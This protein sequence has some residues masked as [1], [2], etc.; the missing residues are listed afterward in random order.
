MRFNVAQLLKEGVGARRWYA[1][2]ETIDTLPETGTTRVKGEV[3]VTRIDK[4][5]W[6]NGA[7]ETNASCACSRCL[8]QAEY[9]V[10]FQ[11]DEEYLPTVDIDTG[12]TL[13]VEE[14]QEVREGTFTLDQNH[15]LDLTEAIRQYVIINLPMK[16]LCRQTCPGLCPSCGTNLNDRSCDCSAQPD[17]RW[18]PLLDL[19]TAK[20]NG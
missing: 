12:T 17:L 14:T 15:T 5:V 6:V 20:G 11:L 9:S 2:E 19:L 10:H 1:L 7:V 13:K 4:G 16:P 18:S 3:T 8:I